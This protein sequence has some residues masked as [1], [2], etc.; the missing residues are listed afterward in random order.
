M[1]ADRWR[2]ITRIYAAVANQPIENRRGALEAA[3]G[4]DETLRREVA[5]LLAESG[6]VVID[7]PAAAIAGSLL[8]ETRVA[9]GTMIGVYR[10]ESLLGVGGMG[11][12]YRA[13]DTKL[14]R[15]VA[16]KVLPAV[17]AGDPDR[18]AR[19]K[20]EAHV[21][22]S[23]NHPNIAT[24]HGF[25]DSNGVHAIAMELV[26][27]PTLADR[28]ARGPMPFDEALPIARQIAEALEAAHEQ[29]IVHRDL[30]PANIKVRDDGTVKV[31]DFGLAKIAEDVRPAGT[32]RAGGGHTQSPTITTP[33]MTAAGI[34]LGT[35]AYMS[36]EQAKGKPADKRSDIWAFG[37]VLYEMLTGKRAFEGD[38]VAETLAAILRG[39]PDWRALDATRT[40][41]YVATF[42]RRCLEKNR[43]RRIPGL[44]IAMYVLD[45]PMTAGAST[46][47]RPTRSRTLA[48]AAA[49][50]LVGAVA[51]AAVWMLTRP[52]TM[53]PAVPARFAIVP[54]AP[55]APMFQGAD[56]DIAIS[57]DGRF[58]AYR[59]GI[60]Q[61]RLFLRR[62]DELEPKP[63]TGTGD[64]RAPFFSPD[65]NWVGFW[66]ASVFYKI[67]VNGGPAIALYQSVGPPRGASWGDDN[68]IVVATSD[69][70]TGLI[71]VPANGGDPQTLT[72]PNRTQHE[73]DHWF[74]FVMPGGRSILFTIMS[75]GQTEE[76]QLAVL[77]V[78]T[79]HVKTIL[80][81]ASQAEYIEPGF[82]VFATA[83][84]LRAVPFDPIRLETTGDP[85]P[86]LEGVLT[87]GT[88]AANFGLS[89]LGTLV[90]VPGSVPPITRSL[91]WVDRA[92]REQPIPAPPGRYVSAA[93][94]PDETQL[95]IEI[96]DQ[97][98]DVW[99]L[100]LR[101]KDSAPRRLT[102][103]QGQLPV[104]TPDGKF[105][106]FSSGRAGAPNLYRRAADGSGRDE[107]LT[108]SDNPQ[109]ASSITSDGRILGHEI[110]SSP[111]LALF[112]LN[113]PS[114]ASAGTATDHRNIVVAR[115]DI[116]GVF[117][118]ISPDERFIAY[119]GPGSSGFEIFVRPFPNLDGGVWQIS[120]AGG[121]KPIWGR[122][123]HELFFIDR[124]FG[125]MSVRTETTGT[126]FVAGTPSRVFDHP[127]V[128][129][130]AVPAYDVSKTGRL[131]IL[132]EDVPPSDAG[133][134][135][136]LV[137]VERWFE[138][139]KAK[140]STR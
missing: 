51:V 119:A 15:D 37:C 79:R 38:D 88:G 33:A 80:R 78:A 93:L 126:A 53:A 111:F 81:G 123:G 137:V 91:M 23:L 90:Y 5:S 1:N 87:G 16:I 114:S 54:P 127:Y 34:I 56:R 85:F 66:R 71:R 133:A 36:P 11:E 72:R 84:T 106:V 140:A 74:P 101:R 3:C 121:V 108:T 25:E 29:G 69:P 70:A 24:V 94:S 30:K 77:D 129:S 76:R 134:P 58:I 105:I 67:S 102:F 28:I 75:T 103:E 31:L 118:A 59:G 120:T 27:G 42:V 95:A 125:P 43:E 50:V 89:R 132:K 98:S 128:A 136:S 32:S 92:G 55:Q 2:Q 20:R 68:T 116:A 9:P 26:E 47:A 19:F 63:L 52:A 12:V 73:T 82:L 139:L 100:D 135:A 113:P 115:T 122:D 60:G 8:T 40:P 21:L 46:A 117:P 130:G 61:P 83:G 45:Q 86:V 10:V 18:L 14:Q 124:A 22:A 39:E 49:G 41:E 138:E 64:V 104:W 110:A 48:V 62:L 99:I 4:D 7:S 96:S 44:S 35:A 17:L 109:L 57:R 107:R 65:G 112:T 131:L 6:A 13:R 97:H